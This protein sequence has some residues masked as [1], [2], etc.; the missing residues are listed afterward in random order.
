MER[1]ERRARVGVEADVLEAGDAAGIAVV[2]DRILREVER[3]AVGGADDLVHGRVVRLLRAEAELEGRH[4]RVRPLAERVQEPRDVARRDEGFVALDVD[5][6]VGGARLATSQTRSV[7][8]GWSA[9]VR[10]AG[11]PCRAQAW[12]TSSASVATNT[13]ARSGERRAASQ[14]WTTRGL[15]AMSRSTLRGR[16]VEPR[17]AG[18]TPRAVRR[19]LTSPPSRQ[20]T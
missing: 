9:D 5:V 18:T 1:L 19:R 13:S 14:T 10:I 7:P 11:T 20:G 4:L 6:D 8:D 2:G 16:R 15:P 3:V 17:R 12:T